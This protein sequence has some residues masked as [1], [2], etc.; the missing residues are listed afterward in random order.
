M[1]SSVVQTGSWVFGT[2]AWTWDLRAPLRHQPPLMCIPCTTCSTITLR[3]ALEFGAPPYTY[4]SK[5]I[6]GR[7]GHSYFYKPSQVIFQVCRGLRITEP[8]F[9]RSGVEGKWGQ[10]C[11]C[12]PW[13][14][15]PISWNTKSYIMKHQV[16]KSF[17]FL[18][19][20]IWVGEWEGEREMGTKE[21][22]K[23][24]SLKDEKGKWGKEMTW[25]SN[26]SGRR[27]NVTGLLSKKREED[28][29]FCFHWLS[30]V[31][32][33]APILLPLSTSFT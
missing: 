9:V 7:P 6:E 23:G 20:R 31:P 33:R 17:S 16:V 21:L 15:H 27:G 19:R 13:S 22:V 12:V 2:G 18:S 3:S 11:L 29:I 10:S 14:S 4:D 24:K 1:A 8:H 25:I 32:V 28:Q 5:S 30:F 26:W